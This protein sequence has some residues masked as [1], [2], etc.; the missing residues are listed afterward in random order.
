MR[1]SLSVVYRDPVA[2]PSWKLLVWR[3]AFT[4]LAMKCGLCGCSVLRVYGADPPRAVRGNTALASGAPPVTVGPGCQPEWGESKTDEESRRGER[5]P[6]AS[7]Q[8]LDA[9]NPRM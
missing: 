2:L 6:N 8:T 1:W 4:D 9:H 5:K 3:K 7:V